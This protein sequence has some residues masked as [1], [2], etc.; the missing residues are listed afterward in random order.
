MKKMFLF[1]MAFLFH[2]CD[3]NAQEIS[4]NDDNATASWQYSAPIY[5]LPAD[6]PES[7]I[8]KVDEDA[9][10]RTCYCVVSYDNLTNQ[11]HRTGQCLD[12]TGVVNTSYSSMSEA[13]RNKCN[14]KCTT[15]ASNLTA[16][17]KQNI[18]NC[19]CAAGKPTGTVIRAYSALSTKDYK[20]AQQIGT[21]TNS[22]ESTQTTCKCPVGWWANTSNVDG[23]ITADGQCKK[24]VCSPIG[25]APWVRLQFDVL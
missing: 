3:T 16:A 19:V 12:L 2:F 20:T 6:I 13:N 14:D 17:Q 1:L 23:G 4:L 21:L 24:P 8:V 22:P 5:K 7:E 15:A 18:A 25:V 11:P 10:K 9:S